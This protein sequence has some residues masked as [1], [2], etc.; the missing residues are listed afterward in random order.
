M[1]RW[2]PFSKWWIAWAV[3][4]SVIEVAAVV[5]R[6]TTPGGTL[7]STIGRILSHPLTLVPFLALWGYLAYHFLKHRPKR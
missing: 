1:K 6:D 7:S 2:N 4:G 3:A 5:Q